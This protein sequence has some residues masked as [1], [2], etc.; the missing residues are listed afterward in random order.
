MRRAISRLSVAALLLVL[1]G[2]PAAHPGAPSRACT[3]RA[4]CYAGEVCDTMAQ[5]CVAV[6]R[7]LSMPSDQAVQLPADLS[8]PADLAPEDAQ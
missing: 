8:P 3:E 7:D 6:A 1:G 2:C 4:D 5:L